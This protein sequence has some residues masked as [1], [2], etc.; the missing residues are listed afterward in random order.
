MD[1]CVYRG[2]S[3]V[4]QQGV[5]QVKPCTKA[6][7]PHPLFALPSTDCTFSSDLP[8]AWATWVDFIDY[9]WADDE[10]VTVRF[11]YKEYSHPNCRD[12]G[13][14]GEPFFGVSGMDKLRNLE[15]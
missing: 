14:N 5:H 6:L 9:T 1:S 3:Y 2:F 10:N 15:P 11:V 12:D 7:L 13:P 8:T 4:D